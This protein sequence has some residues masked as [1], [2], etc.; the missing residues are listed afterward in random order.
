MKFSINKFKLISFWLLKCYV[1]VVMLSISS[2]RKKPDIN[3]VDYRAEMKTFVE[4]IS[5]YAKTFNASFDIIPQ[6][7]IDLIN[8][9][10]NSLDTTYL[11]AI[12]G[13]GQ[14]ELN[15]GYNN[16]D[17]KPTP[18][19]DHDALLQ[20]VLKFTENHKTVLVTDYTDDH[21]QADDAIQQ[22]NANG[23]LFLQPQMILVY[24]KHQSR[25]HN[26]QAA[27]YQMR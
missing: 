11:N 10:S 16:H 27:E 24:R 20:N 19:A 5:A 17:N 3:G 13:C 9:N 14:E 18:F 6:N 12:S 22:N 2:C 7:G 23:F 25:H 21:T 26:R 1:L 8:Q 4:G 15:Y